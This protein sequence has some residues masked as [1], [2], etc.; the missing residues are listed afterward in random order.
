MLNRRIRLCTLEKY[1]IDATVFI[2]YTCISSPSSRFFLATCFGSQVSFWTSFELVGVC[3]VR[4]FLW[5]HQKH[6]QFLSLLCCS[7]IKCFFKEEVL[8][9]KNWDNS[10][11]LTFLLIFV[12][13]LLGTLFQEE[14][15]SAK[16]AKWNI[17]QAA[18][19]LALHFSRMLPIW[20]NAKP[21]PFLWT[22]VL[23][24]FEC[25]HVA[26]FCHIALFQCLWHQWCV[27]ACVAHVDYPPCEHR[28]AL[29]ASAV[30]CGML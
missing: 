4:C 29:W 27:S 20:T 17:L 7:L 25:A 19:L 23:L 9:D 13:L 15:P 28:G 26:G 18:G 24:C 21:H 14:L 30:F 2:F 12:L 8:Q 10:D 3:L 1:H 5:Q 22:L 16:C 6:S 11:H